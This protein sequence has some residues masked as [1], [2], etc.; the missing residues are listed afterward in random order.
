MT[1]KFL[2]L[3]LMKQGKMTRKEHATRLKNWVLKIL[4]KEYG[5]KRSLRNIWRGLEGD[6]KVDYKKR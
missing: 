3:S 4:V 6:K 2:L 5:R 1:W